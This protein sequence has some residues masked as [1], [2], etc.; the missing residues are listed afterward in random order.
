MANGGHLM[1]Q[2]IGALTGVDLNNV[3]EPGIYAVKDPTNG[4]AAGTYSVEVNVAID[5]GTRLMVQRALNMS[6]G[7]ISTRRYNG[8][9]WTAW[10]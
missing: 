4:P 1:R 9:S 3:T 10:A 5:G 8:T 2:R 6:S 7:A